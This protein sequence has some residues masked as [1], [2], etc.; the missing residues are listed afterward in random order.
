ML[1]VAAALA[2]TTSA[3]ADSKPAANPPSYGQNMNFRPMPCLGAGTWAAGLITTAFT[4][5]SAGG[6][7]IKSVNVTVKA[8]VL[9]VYT[10]QKDPSLPS[11]IGMQSI[12]QTLTLPLGT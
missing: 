5:K 12:S 8:G 11:Y 9:F 2:A 4:V 10:A 3:F 7:T 6:K 1:V